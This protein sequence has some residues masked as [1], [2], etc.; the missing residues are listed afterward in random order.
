MSVTAGAV[1]RV[2]AVSV[3]VLADGAGGPDSSVA[4]EEFA[5]VVTLSSAQPTAAPRISGAAASA[6]SRR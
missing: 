2:V 6:T 1:G 4:S 5:I 3:E